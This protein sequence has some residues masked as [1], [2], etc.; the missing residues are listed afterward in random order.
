MK[1]NVSNW[2]NRFAVGANSDAQRALEE[3]N[4]KQQ[5]RSLRL[6]AGVA[7][8]L[9]S[10][11]L[12]GFTSVIAGE[13]AGGAI[14]S[15]LLELGPIIFVSNRSGIISGT[16]NGNDLWTMNAN[17]TNPVALTDNDY[18]EFEPQWNPSGTKIAFTSN[19]DAVTRGAGFATDWDVYTMNP[20]GSDVVNLTP[21]DPG[22]PSYDFG[23]TWSPDG[24]KIAFA[25]DRDAPG[26]GI[27]KIYVMNA[28]G[29]GT[30][31]RLTNTAGSEGHPAWS[32]DG[33][34]IAFK[35]SRHGNDEI[36][37][38]NVVTGVQT[39]L[40]NNSAAD[41]SPNWSPDGSKIAFTSSRTGNTDVYSMNASN[42]S[43][44]KRLTTNNAEENEP[45][46]SPDGT[47][48][49][50]YRR[51]DVENQEIYIMN[52]DGKKQVRLTNNYPFSDG[53]PTW[54]P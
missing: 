45:A 4:M 53:D 29:S 28:D 50:F 44:L 18:A 5:N 36:Y 41:W 26:S 13:P 27:H 10:G 37:V 7:T 22:N 54:K 32:K 11:L 23:S 9:S 51:H 48:I 3:S 34:K 19:E 30:P 20:D 40:T 17:G 6:I 42:G 47:K 43:G 12:V 46:Y 35:D 33:T 39:R 52:A 31:V 2:S 25:S 15:P 38:I 21:D 1:L 49:V 24:T 14:K 16:P 8:I